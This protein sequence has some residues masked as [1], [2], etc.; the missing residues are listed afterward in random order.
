MP[1]APIYLI[2]ASLLSKRAPACC[3]RLWALSKLYKSLLHT[4]ITFAALFKHFK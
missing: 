1:F 3:L 2:A 4:L